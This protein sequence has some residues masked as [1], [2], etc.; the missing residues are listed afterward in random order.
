MPRPL[1]LIFL[2][3]ATSGCRF[4][5]AQEAR[6]PLDGPTFRVQCNYEFANCQ[7]AAEANCRGPYEPITRQN[8]PRCGKL[9]PS[10]PEKNAPVQQPSYRGTLYYRCS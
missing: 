5:A 6:L 2:L 3:A 9:V 10:R 1:L 8:C 4:G 7:R